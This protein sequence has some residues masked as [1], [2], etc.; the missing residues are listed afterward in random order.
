MKYKK[1][2]PYMELRATAP[3]RIDDVGM[4]CCMSESRRHCEERSNMA[5]HCIYGYEWLASPDKSGSQNGQTRSFCH[6][7]NNSL[8]PVK[9][10]ENMTYP[11][12]RSYYKRT[13][14]LTAT[15]FYE[16]R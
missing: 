15:I 14:N 5:I 11:H 1:K 7:P 6:F 9:H 4:P 13:V 10:I 12:I 2:A 3:S 8:Y 16:Y